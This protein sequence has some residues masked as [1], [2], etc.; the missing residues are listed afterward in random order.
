MRVRAVG[1]SAGYE[2]ADRVS[3]RT[4][5]TRRASRG[6]KL[7]SDISRFKDLFRIPISPQNDRLMIELPDELDNHTRRGAKVGGD[8]DFVAIVLTDQI[9]VP[10]AQRALYVAGLIE[11]ALSSRLDL[12]QAAVEVQADE[13]AA[14]AARNNVK[15][16]L[17]IYGILQTRGSSL[18]PYTLPVFEGTGIT[19]ASP[20]LFEG[21]LKISAIHQG[22]VQLGTP[23][24]NRIA[25]AD[26]ARD[27]IRRRQ[28]PG[29]T[30]M[31]KMILDS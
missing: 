24:R 19:T 31:R 9:V 23:L 18:V 17:N 6:Q 30:A 26:P 14:K 21:G 16:E 11:G 3:R 1:P 12:V 29:R 15:P 20:A 10:V 8:T 2:T 22:G 7:L 25:Q 27:S 28:V 13:I 5:E 4:P